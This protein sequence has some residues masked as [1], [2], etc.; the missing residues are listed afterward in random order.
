MPRAGAPLP[1]DFTRF[2]A[3]RTEVV[4]ATHLA[5]MFREIVPRITIYE[6]AARHPKARALAGRGAAY[7]VPLPADIDH[8]VVRHNRHG[9]LFAPITR[10]LF[11]APTFAPR[12]L[13]LSRRLLEYGVHTPAMLAYALYPAPLGF[14]RADVVTREVP[15]SFDLSVAFMSSDAAFRASAIAATADLVLALSATGAHH[16]DLNI[17]NVLLHPSPG[18]DKTLEAMVLDLDRVRFDDADIVLDWNLERLLRS[19]HKWRDERGALVTQDE[20]DELAGSV[21]ERRPA[22]AESAS[23]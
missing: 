22:P 7:A 19:A 21:R 2:F 23:S 3:G 6:Y 18:N 15:N 1:A 9:G 14:C 16:V 20:L 8:M 5:L 4:C 11:R 10:D 17:K 13:Y 12:E